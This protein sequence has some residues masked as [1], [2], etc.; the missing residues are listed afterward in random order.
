[1]NKPRN[2]IHIRLP[3]N[4]HALLKDETKANGNTMQKYVVDAIEKSL[5]NKRIENDRLVKGVYQSRFSSDL[6]VSIQREIANATFVNLIGLNLLDFLSDDGW[7][8][9]CL[10]T[11][12]Q[13]QNV[14][15]KILILDKDSSSFNWRLSMEYEIEQH[16][17]RNEQ[18]SCNPKYLKSREA[19]YHLQEII[20]LNDN[21]KVKKYSAYPLFRWMLQV[22][23]SMFVE[24]HCYR[25]DIGADRC[26]QKLPVFFFDFE[27]ASAKRYSEH[28]NTVWSLSDDL[29]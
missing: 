5:L 10:N 21:I 14:K 9:E 28:F 17:D 6:L 22:N 15:T 12:L 29:K 7:G 19:E 18:I 16:D 4:L 2:I 20:K 1:M 23:N 13:S 11:L 8:N 24:H 3:E 26:T 25:K 27:S